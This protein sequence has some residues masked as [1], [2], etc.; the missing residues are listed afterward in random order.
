M[1]LTLQ[2]WDSNLS[3]LVSSVAAQTREKIGGRSAPSSLT[4]GCKHA[5]KPGPP[6]SLWSGP[7]L[8]ARCVWKA[9]TVCP[10]KAPQALAVSGGILRCHNLVGGWEE[11]YW[12]PVG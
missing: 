5:P 2:Q 8:A 6:F 1:A 7:P 12:H 11:F 4:M 3:P 9:L 10:K